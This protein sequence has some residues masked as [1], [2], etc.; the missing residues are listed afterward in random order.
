MQGQEAPR[1]ERPEP[2]VPRGNPAT[3]PR[4]ASRWERAPAHRRNNAAG[5]TPA[6]SP[7][8][9]A[10]RMRSAA[11][12]SKEPVSRRGSAAAGG[13]AR[14]RGAAFPWEPLAPP[15]PNAA[16]R[17]R[18][19]PRCS[20]VHPRRSVARRSSRRAPRTGTAAAACARTACA[21]ACPSGPHAR[22]GGSA[23]LTTASRTSAAAPR[24]APAPRP[25]NA[26]TR[27]A[28]AARVSDLVPPSGPQRTEDRCPGLNLTWVRWTRSRRSP[29][30]GTSTACESR[31]PDRRPA[32]AIRA[33]R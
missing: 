11:C 31:P 19:P 9:P 24:D 29:S 4:R 23:A 6:R 13:P 26:A 14:T 30:A 28:R 16:A 8:S 15:G 10:A 27:L 33:C 22:V 12:P 1:P 25:T 17:R 7:P 18:R 32:R 20:V 5:S 2:Q 21:D 3:R